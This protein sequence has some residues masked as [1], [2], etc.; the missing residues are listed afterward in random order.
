MDIKI[1]DH[2]LREAVETK[3]TPEKIKECL[4]LCGQS[5]NRLTKEGNDFVYEIEVTTNRPD[6]LSVYGIGRE[7]SAI[8]PQF[9][10]SAKLKEIPT[11]KIKKV[12]SGLPL[13]VKISKKD[14]CPRFTAL[15]FENV[16]IR[17]SP[18][19]V[20]E[21]LAIAGIRTLNNV[22]DISNYLMLEL[23]QPMHTF[24]YDK[25]LKHK[26]I[27]RES[28]EGETVITLDGQERKLPI[29]TIVIEDGEGRLI[30]LCGIMGAKNSETD[31]NTKRVLLFVQTYD[32]IKIRKTC[33]ELG[34]RTE[35]A[36]RFEKGIDPEGVIPAMERAN[37][38]FKEWCGANEGSELFDIY[39]NPYQEK[40]VSVSLD[41]IKKITGLEIDLEK[42]KEILESLGFKTKINQDDKLISAK[43]P[44]FR[45]NDINI[46][47]DLIEEI[48]RIYGYFNLPDVLPPLPEKI[49]DS[50]NQ[51]FDLEYKMKIALK[52][53]GFTEVM[54]YSLVSEE[55]LD[56][57]HEDP[58]KLL[59]I[60]NP[61]SS[62]LIFLR[63]SL[64]P[65]LLEIIANNNSCGQIFEMA[66]VYISKGRENLPDESLEL[67]IATTKDS[68]LELKGIMESLLR[69][70]S[71]NS[72]EM[73]IDDRFEHV[74]LEKTIS[75]YLGDCN[76]GV[77]GQIRSEILKNMGIKNPI[78]IADIEIR[79]LLRFAGAGK[80][81]SPL[82]K[83]PPI[84]ED[85]SFELPPK[86]YIGP[87]IETIK[88]ED[89]LVKSV[90]L[91]D[92]FE[93]TRTFRISYQS[94][95]NN[96]SNEEVEKIR[97][98]V[99]EK[100]GKKFSGTLKT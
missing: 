40:T 9:G 70:L 57:T 59:K 21:R 30:D 60:A 54:S 76:I 58:K 8:L 62:D 32:P 68:F 5:V 11:L 27:L 77:M 1:S 37:F 82:P 79:R 34:F 20:H 23:G 56:K 86:T 64:I 12:T 13:S 51:N 17:P 53:W 95:E 78:W 45:A 39:P 75:L 97:K 98:K 63:T 25:I 81:Y 14:L 71:I 85:L 26:M 46:P 66:N 31:E 48:A 6:C 44:H 93:R 84:I 72:L 96:L 83:Y 15:V 36:S 89:L 41:Q 10:I 69:E 33:Q 22:I 61:L 47:E 88:E 67:T 99:I 55:L 3:A 65:S 74:F 94:N 91:L 35:A 28:K 19:F 16:T 52:Y 92:S 42:A 43:V 87:V 38:L 73:T 24:D 2:W 50:A 29:G 18:K 49:E 90:E 7:L 100:V 4:S 80:K